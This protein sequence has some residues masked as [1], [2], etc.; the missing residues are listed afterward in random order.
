MLDTYG[1]KHTHSDCLI[2][3]AF[4]LQQWLHEHILMLLY[5]HIARLVFI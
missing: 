4:L 2:L 1:Y 5:T 3:T